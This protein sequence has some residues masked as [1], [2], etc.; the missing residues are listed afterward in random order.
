MD[1][2]KQMLCRVVLNNLLNTE[3]ERSKKQ[4]SDIDNSVEKKNVSV[5]NF[6]F[7]ESGRG[8]SGEA[9][10]RKGGQECEVT[11]RAAIH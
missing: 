8:V 3:T 2:N 6:W 7:S 5:Y 10:A 11:Q 4:T 1:E 9:K